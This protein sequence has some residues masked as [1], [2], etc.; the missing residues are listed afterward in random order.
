[1]NY[2]NEYI[3]K[4]WSHVEL[5]NELVRLIKEYNKIRKCTLLVYAA[6]PESPVPDVALNQKDFYFVKDLLESTSTKTNDLDIYLETPGGR[7]ETAEEIV[8]FVRKKYKKVSFVI[9]GEA[10]SAGTILAMSGDEI[11][12]TDT[13]SLGPIDA[14][15]VIGRSQVSAYDYTNWVNEKRKEALTKPLNQVDI[16]ILAQISPG[17]LEGAINA[18]EYAVQMVKEW[19]V[20]Y[21]FKEWKQTET[22]KQKVNLKMKEERA[23]EI[24][25][26]LN[27]HKKWKTHARSL[28]REDLESLKLKIT[29]V[30]KNEK[31]KEIVYRIHTICRLIYMTGNTY[32]IIATSDNKIAFTF[33]QSPMLNN[34]VQSPEV[35][36]LDV[37]CPKCKSK[38]NLY[39]QL[40]DDNKLDVIATN[41]GRKKFPKDNVLKC[42]CGFEMNLID[43]RNNIEAQTG[44]K[45]ID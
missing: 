28:K 30:E 35:I 24:A 37:D 9:C 41:K 22:T 39:I 20:K 11:L 8:K 45:T 7:G 31:L 17:E 5:E 6:T 13:G 29:D 32:K 44:I 15:M 23:E 1:M 21:K 3:S 43:I 18:Q 4:G 10:K 33:N 12:M 2:L 36:E 26:A 27:N 25:N 34:P 38:H 42:E 40:K 14:Q 16:A 19:L